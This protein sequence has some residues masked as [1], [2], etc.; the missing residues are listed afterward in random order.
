MIEEVST[1]CSS[2]FEPHVKSRLNQVPRNADGGMIDSCETL[3]STHSGRPL[4]FR[5]AVRYLDDDEMNAAH[6]YVLM[7]YEH[8]DLFLQKFDEENKKQF[9]R[10]TG[11]ELET[12]RDRFFSVATCSSEGQ[13]ENIEQ[14]GDIAFQEDEASDPYPILIAIDKDEINIVSNGV[15][16][17]V[18]VNEFEGLQHG[19]D[20]N[21]VII[22]DEDHWEG[23]EELE[24]E[25]DEQEEEYDSNESDEDMNT[26]D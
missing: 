15:L 20:F 9:P 17:E 18:D 26:N 8:I 7:N 19:I 16:E 1:F 24:P 5:I 2:Y 22:E 10:I 13:D 11:M 14:R 3:F 12:L 6:K 23:E 25:D 4:D 21:E